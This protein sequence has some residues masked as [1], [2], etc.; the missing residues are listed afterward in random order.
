MIRQDRLL[1][2]FLNLVR[3]DGPVG[4]EEPV[5]AEVVARLR[6]L[7]CSVRRDAFGNVLAQSAGEGGPTLLLN[8]HLDCV[9][10][11]LGIRP[12]VDGDVVRS[13]GTTVLGADNRA[14]VAAALEVLASLNE[15]GT[16]HLPLE[17]V[18]T[19]GEEAGLLGAKALDCSLL[20]A[21]WGLTLDDAGSVGGC[22]VSTPWHDVI[23]A[24]IHGRA[25]HSGVEPEKGISAIQTAALGIAAMRLGRI[26]A[27]TTANVGKITG[28][29]AMNIVAERVDL[30]AEARSR[31]EDKLKR[32]T[33]SMVQ[34][35]DVAAA[36]TGARADI[37]VARAYNGYSLSESEPILVRMVQAARSLDITPRLQATGGGS[38][39]NIFHAQGITILNL[40]AGYENAHTVRESI[41]VGELV[42]LASLVEAIV[43]V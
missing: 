15:D 11:C 42:K 19:L 28:G 27:E 2:S 23:K 29:T 26:D 37:E 33:S 34:A 35:L 38:D 17:I 20:Q 22:V 36:Q 25:A 4:G 43:R 6:S 12:V 8:A 40:S 18:F 21:R 31:N 9:Q 39:A 41:S 14:G 13:D 24:T 30:V 32:Q 16:R 5:A 3:L 1:N 10:P 7:G